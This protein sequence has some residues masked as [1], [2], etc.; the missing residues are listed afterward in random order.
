MKTEKKIETVHFKALL[1]PFYHASSDS[2]AMRLWVYGG[3]LYSLSD[4][5]VLQFF[6][7]NHFLPFILYPFFNSSIQ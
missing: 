7:L 1:Q 6:H 5:K 2:Q 3:S 4:F